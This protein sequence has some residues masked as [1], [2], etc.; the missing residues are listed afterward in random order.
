MDIM[1]EFIKAMIISRKWADLTPC[2]K[3]LYPVFGNKGAINNPD[4]KETNIYAAGDIYEYKKYIEWAGISQPSFKSACQGLEHKDLIEFE[5]EEDFCEYYV[6][7]LGFE[8]GV[9]F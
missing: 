1:A 7:V 4:I 9:Q 2:E 6:Y 5:E 8:R 3:S